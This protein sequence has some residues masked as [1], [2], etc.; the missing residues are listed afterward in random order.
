MLNHEG[1]EVSRRFGLQCFFL[2]YL[3]ALGGQSVLLRPLVK[4]EGPE[5]K[6]GPVKSYFGL[7][8]KC[9]RGIVL[10][11]NLLGTVGQSFGLRQQIQTF[12]NFWIRLRAHLQAFIFAESVG[13]NF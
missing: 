12:Q 7:P 1:H 11:H 6:S 5:K 2:V 3:R 10:G 9:P 4:S 8:I 13:K